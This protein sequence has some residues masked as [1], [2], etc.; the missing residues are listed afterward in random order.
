MF[1][2]IN[3]EEAAALGDT[4]RAGSFI[5]YDYAKRHRLKMNSA[6]GKVSMASSSWNSLVKRL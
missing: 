2:L 4:E 3:N 6:T 1:I 5:A